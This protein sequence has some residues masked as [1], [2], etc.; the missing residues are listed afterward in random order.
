[1]CVESKRRDLLDSSSSV[2]LHC[3]RNVMSSVLL[4]RAAQSFQLDEGDVEYD[5]QA[6][7]EVRDQRCC[8]SRRRRAK[9]CDALR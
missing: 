1:M 4:A 8:D 5:A 9:M 3:F 2:E 7:R 6:K